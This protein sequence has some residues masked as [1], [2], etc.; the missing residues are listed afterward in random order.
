[1]TDTIN[2]KQFTL[3]VRVTDNT[4]LWIKT[5]FIMMATMLRRRGYNPVVF[6]DDFF[7]G[8]QD[9]LGSV[10]IQDTEFMGETG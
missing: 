6:S 1:M 7:L 4:D 3:Q 9:I 10:D 5:R 8:H 2:P